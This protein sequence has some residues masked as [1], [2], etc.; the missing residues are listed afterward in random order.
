MDKF[1]Y[2][3]DEIRELIGE[4]RVE[5]LKEITKTKGREISPE[6]MDEL[7]KSFVEGGK[8]I[9]S[10]KKEI[11]DESY[12]VDLILKR[13][14]EGLLERLRILHQRGECAGLS[15][16]YL[17]N[18]NEAIKYCSSSIEHLKLAKE[19]LTRV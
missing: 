10:A 2:N 4:R 11:E 9:Y 17:N 3:M 1:I 15:K 18:I 16:E 13:E 6:E 12:M 19:T 7:V 8:E 5:L 14:A